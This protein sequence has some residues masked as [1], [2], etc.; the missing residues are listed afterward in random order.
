MS[1]PNYN[2]QL[3]EEAKKWIGVHEDKSKGDNCGK[4]VEMFQKAVDGKA[5]KESW[6]MA[7]VQFCIKQ[8][9]QKNKIQCLVF[10]SEHCLTVFRESQSKVVKDPQPGDLII[11]RF[12][13]TS[14]GHVGII[15][16][17]LGEGRCMTIEGNT[18]NSQ[19]VEREGD[20]VFSKNRSLKGS[21]QMRVVGF[22]RPF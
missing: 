2:L 13:N 15:E 4:E 21:E 5:Q 3:I 16:K 1:L 22:I 20:G 19:S 7:F 12:G 8:V 6:C 10:K 17:L 11:W 9:E 18:S 14:N